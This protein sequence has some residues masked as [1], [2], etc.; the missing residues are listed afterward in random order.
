[1]PNWQPNWNDVQWDWGAAEEAIR[2]LRSSA[3][4]LDSTSRERARLAEEAQAQWRGRYRKEFDS[5]FER[6]QRRSRDLA[7]QIRDSADRIASASHRA[8]EE[9]RHREAE[10]QRWQ[11]E[12]EDEE[13]RAREERE[14]REREEQERRQREGREPGRWW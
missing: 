9:Q 2:A 7:A 13:R 6:I 4:L 12:R 11:R 14:R 5:E 1:M 8:W 3:D 10:R